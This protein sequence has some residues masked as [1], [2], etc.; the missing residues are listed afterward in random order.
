MSLQI[1][2]MENS[3]KILQFSYLVLCLRCGAIVATARV[4]LPA[5]QHCL[6]V[7]N[8]IL[9]TTL[10]FSEYKASR[11][12]SRK[13]NIL[14]RTSFKT[15]PIQQIKTSFYFSSHITALDKD[16]WTLKTS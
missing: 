2:M 12:Q 3:S 5:L 14:R 6:S 16:S 8:V 9:A 15:A 13:Q 11:L 1:T 4:H 10:N 7:D